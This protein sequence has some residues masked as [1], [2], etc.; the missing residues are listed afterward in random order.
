MTKR[1]CCRISLFFDMANEAEK[2]NPSALLRGVDTKPDVV[3]RVTTGGSGAFVALGGA[4]DYK[5][6]RDEGYSRRTSA[7]ASTAG[8]VAG[9]GTTW[10]LVTSATGLTASGVGTIVGVA[11]FA[12]LAGG[13][14]GT[15]TSG[16]V[17]ERAVY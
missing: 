5:L 16:W 8:A 13:Y 10:L 9:G 6:S 3:T 2:R 1:R 11:L 14:A 12:A 17:K 15:I 4:L 7:T